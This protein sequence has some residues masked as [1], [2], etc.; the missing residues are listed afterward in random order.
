MPTILSGFCPSHLGIIDVVSKTPTADS[1]QPYGISPETKAEFAELTAL[2]ATLRP[3][4]GF[5]H[6]GIGPAEEVIVQFD[7]PQALE[8]G[9]SQVAELLAGRDYRCIV[10][11][12]GLRLNF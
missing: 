3:V 6:V 10:P 11:P 9:K 2:L 8:S 1:A 12:D 4:R 7:D 5:R